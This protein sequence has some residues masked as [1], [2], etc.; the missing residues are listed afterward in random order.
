MKLL[1][2]QI[3]RCKLSSSMMLSLLII[4]A[5]S[6]N[7]W[8]SVSGD[9]SHADQYGFLEAWD[10]GPGQDVKIG[11]PFK[12]RLEQAEMTEYLDAAI[13]LITLHEIQSFN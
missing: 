11:P 13:K 12:K 3:K 9:A 7:Y 5:F 2:I 1:L 6:A 4:I 10:T 8:G